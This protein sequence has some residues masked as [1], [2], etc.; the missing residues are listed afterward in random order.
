MKEQINL[1]S[2]ILLLVRRSQ[3]LIKDSNKMLNYKSTQPVKKKE[4]EIAGVAKLVKYMKRKQF[5][6]LSLQEFLDIFQEN[7]DEMLQEILE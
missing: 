7:T 4:S 1:A 2:S 6:D 3:L 5:G